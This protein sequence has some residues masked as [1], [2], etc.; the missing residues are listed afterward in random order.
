VKLKQIILLGAEGRMGLEISSLATE[1]GLSVL[2]MGKSSKRPKD[3]SLNKKSV[4]IDFSSPEGFSKG[5]T[6]CLE[7]GMPFLSGTT[8]LQKSD[9]AAL[10]KA[11]KKIPVLWA[12]NMSIGVQVLAQMLKQ[13]A[14]TQKNFDFK[15]DEI[16]HKHKKDSPSGTAL[17]LKKELEGA[18]GA[19]KVETQSLRGGGVF[20]IHKVLALGEEEILSLEHVALNRK[21]FARGALLAA[22]W[23]CNQDAGNYKMGQVLGFKN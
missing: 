5:L 2:P 1:S 6:Y 16:H 21:V 22:E 9:F 8:G 17:Y 18:V 19:G 14:A 3:K 20:G 23:L 11:S 12:A 13:F 4:L 15:I 7:T 10:E